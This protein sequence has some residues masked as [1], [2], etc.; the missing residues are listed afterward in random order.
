MI[1]DVW[2]LDPVSVKGISSWTSPATATTFNPFD[3]NIDTVRAKGG[4]GY[5]QMNSLDGFIGGAA[6]KFYDGNLSCLL[7]TSPSPRDS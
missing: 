5:C 7:Y 6:W 3:D 1:D 2:L 4:S